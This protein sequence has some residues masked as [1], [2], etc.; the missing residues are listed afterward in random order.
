MSDNFPEIS[1]LS[2]DSS[3]YL[4]DAQ[5]VYQEFRSAFRELR[6]YRGGMAWK[7]SGGKEYLYRLRSGGNGKSLGP[8]SAETEEICR[9]FHKRKEELGARVKSMRQRL[10]ER[11]KMVKA[12]GIARVPKKAAAVLRALDVEGLMVTV[13][14]T[15]ALYAYEA[16]AGVRFEPGLLATDDIDLRVSGDVDE[17]GLLYVLKKADKSFEIVRDGHYRASNK[18]GF[19]VELVQCPSDAPTV[20]AIAVGADGYPVWMRVPSPVDFALNKLWLSKSRRDAAQALA[21]ARVGKGYFGLS[22]DLPSDRRY[23][24]WVGERLREQLAQ[25]AKR[26]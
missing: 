20:E 1:E 19:L 4:T 3:R 24:S 26:K 21:V 8:R 11:S 18:D 12:A 25:L 2:L 10:D 5:Q 17:K 14:G 9:A 6:R 23:P 15:H 13:L 22:F 16:M 7:V